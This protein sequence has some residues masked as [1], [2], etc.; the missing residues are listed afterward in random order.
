MVESNQLRK[1]ILS[2]YEIIWR[3]VYSIMSKPTLTVTQDNTKKVNDLIRQFKNDRV[4]VG[5]PE[6]KGARE[7]EQSDVPTNAALLAINEFGSP[8]QNIPARPVMEIGLALSS[9]E[10]AEQFKLAVQEGLGKGGLRAMERRYE[11]AGIV[12]SQ[13]IKEVINGNLFIAPPSEATIIARRYQGFRGTKAL[14]VTG[15]MRNA[16]T[17]VVKKGF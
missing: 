1:T 10:I 5:I 8:E 2:S 7:D 16:I 17:Y 9:E 13:S 12:A 6:S 14:I 11:R 3:G 15:Q 4:L